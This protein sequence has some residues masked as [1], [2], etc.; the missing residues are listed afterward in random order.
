MA[1]TWV[2]T[3]F[4][5][6]ASS[7]CLLFCVGFLWADRRAAKDALK[8]KLAAGKAGNRTPVVEQSLGVPD[9]SG[10]AKLAE[11]LQKL[12]PSG[13]LLV[14]AVAFAA[15][16]AVLGGVGSVAGR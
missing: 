8:G 1:L 10:I 2:V 3:V 7:I 16:A 12:N 14:G 9:F 6:I 13:Q 5:I 11:A 4:C 15:I